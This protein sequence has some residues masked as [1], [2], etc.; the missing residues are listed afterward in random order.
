MTSKKYDFDQK[1]ALVTGSSSGIGAAAVLQFARCNARVV[2][3]GLVAED[4]ESVSKQVE[5]I[6]GTKPLSFTGDLTDEAFATE[7]VESTVKTYGQID[8][9]V[10]NAGIAILG[11]KFGVPDL[12]DRYDKIMSINLRLPFL[13]TQLCLPYLESTKGCIVNTSSVAAYSS[14]VNILFLFSTKVF[15]QFVFIRT[16][17]IVLQKLA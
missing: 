2:V 12:M 13:M 9:L 10:N 7:V 17:F 16:Q 1:V 8:I 14:F 15:S 3:N 5:E 4:V 11:S 6:T